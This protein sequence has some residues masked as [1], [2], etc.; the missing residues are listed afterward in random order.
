ML[1]H[2]YFVG[3]KTPNLLNVV[4]EVPKTNAMSEKLEID[5]SNGKVI[6]AEK[7]SPPLPIH[8]HYGAIPETIGDE[9]EALDVL[10]FQG[11][12]PSNVG[13]EI[14]VRPIGV[15][16]TFDGWETRDDKIIAVPNLGKYDHIRETH[17]LPQILA[18][19]GNRI[20]FTEAVT[21]FFE[22]YRGRGNL[23]SDG[24]GNSAEAF[25][26][27]NLGL[28]KYRCA[29]LATS[30]T[31]KHVFPLYQHI[32]IP[33][34]PKHYGETFF[35]EDVE[36]IKALFEK[37]VY[38]SEYGHVVSG[39]DLKRALRASGNQISRSRLRAH[40]RK[41]L[42]QERLRMANLLTKLGSKVYTASNDE[43]WLR[44]ASEHNVTT[45]FVDHESYEVENVAGISSQDLKTVQY[46]RADG[47]HIAIVE[48][49]VDRDILKD[50]LER[51]GLCSSADTCRV[52]NVPDRLIPWQVPTRGG[53][54]YTQLTN[55]IDYGFNIW[56]DKHNRPHLVIGEAVQKI[57]KLQGREHEFESFIE[58]CRPDFEGIH[59]LRLADGL[60][61]GAPT[62]SIDTG[63]AIICN[64]S[65]A[66]ESRRE[67]EQILN[68]PI[69]NNMHM[70][71]DVPGLRCAVFPIDKSVYSILQEGDLLY[72]AGID[73][74][75]IDPLDPMDLLFDVHGLE[76]NTLAKRVK[77]RRRALRETFHGFNT[78]T[79]PRR[80]V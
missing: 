60:P 12:S 2:C 53:K 38:D 36:L 61:Y 47:T 1:E 11:N 44:K 39:F 78:V 76:H 62:N 28:H 16:K 55:W 13:D 74:N 68:R 29:P 9:G 15:F 41:K 10:V 6:H 4:V 63:L 46:R 7:V 20:S 57:A 33:P 21:S 18:E 59:I 25:R 26:I 58:C 69:D 72:H 23:K 40:N 37:Q 45:A 14:E 52:F 80:R 8:W 17:N 24:W 73:R 5:L 65:L 66:E 64:S 67:M 19:S 70:E 51:I 56:P 32:F 27:I 43:S 3:D 22:R 31:N 50:R 54:I 77:E 79:K 42:I 49:G 35:V 75:S 30:E 34:P 48:Q 71:E